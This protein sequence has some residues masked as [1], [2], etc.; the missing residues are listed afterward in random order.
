M[1]IQERLF[2]LQDKKYRDFSA[3]LIPNIPKELVIGVRAPELRKLSKEVFKSPDRGDFMSALPHEYYEED[4]LHAFLIEQ[5]RNFDNCIEELD[6]FL[7]H[8]DNWASCDCMRPKVLGKH[9]NELIEHIKRWISSEH[10]YTI[11]F[12]IGMLMSHFLDGD[13]K[14]EYLDW[15]NVESE[16]YYVNMMCAWFYATAL[17]KQ[18]E[19]TLPY[20]EDK[21]LPKWVHNKAIQKAR[22]SFRV[23]KEQKEY[24]NSLKIRG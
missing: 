6:R 15:A 13:F 9:K 17:A 8:V 20:I 12:G 11:R 22:E 14:P 10:T 23:N 24:L 19:A 18:Y 16:E 2:A 4:N 7:P 5:I 3:A 21:K 1:D